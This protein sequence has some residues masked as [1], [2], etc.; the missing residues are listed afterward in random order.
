MDFLNKILFTQAGS[1]LHLAPGY[2][3][4]T[5]HPDISLLKRWTYYFD[6]VS[7]PNGRPQI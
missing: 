1:Q 6:M 4:L 5:L 7:S 2:I 3:L